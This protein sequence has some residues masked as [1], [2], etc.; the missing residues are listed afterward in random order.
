MFAPIPRPP[1]GAQ[2]LAVERSSRRSPPVTLGFSGWK[3]HRGPGQTPARTARRAIFA[4]RVFGG[5]PTHTIRS[6]LNALPSASVTARATRSSSCSLPLRTAED[7]RDLALHLV[8]DADRSRFGDD[9]ARDRRRARAGPADALPLRCSACRR[10]ARAGS[11][12]RT[13][14]HQCPWPWSCPKVGAARLEVT[15]VVAPDPARHARPWAAAASIPRRP[16]IKPRS[17]NDVHVLAERADRH[18]LDRLRRD[19][20]QERAPTSVPPRVTRRIALT[21]LAS[22]IIDA[23]VFT[24]HVGQ[25]QPCLTG[26]PNAVWMWQRPQQRIDDVAGRGKTQLFQPITPMPSPRPP[27]SDQ[28]GAEASGNPLAA[29]SPRWLSAPDRAALRRG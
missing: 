10:C 24:A 1:R 27:R 17:I 15:L 2:A 26:S 9:A 4:E 28:E 6:G 3:G 11:H 21:M 5:A 14:V 18:W 8:R 16:A 29:A 25:G 22:T 19:R 7:P 12:R 23:G 13:R 20:R